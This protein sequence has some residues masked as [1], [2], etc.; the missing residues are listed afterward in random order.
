MKNFFFGK[1]FFSIVGIKSNE[2]LQQLKNNLSIDKEF[3]REK[4]RIALA[5]LTDKKIF[6]PEPK[7]N[8]Y[9]AV[10]V[11]FHQF[12]GQSPKY[13]IFGNSNLILRVFDAA[14]IDILLMKLDSFTLNEKLLLLQKFHS[15][16]VLKALM[17]N[18]IS[19]SNHFNCNS[20]QIGYGGRNVRFIFNDGKSLVQTNKMKQ[21]LTPDDI[22]LSK[23]ISNLL[24]QVDRDSYNLN[25]TISANELK[26]QIKKQINKIET[27]IAKEKESTVSNQMLVNGAVEIL[28]SGFA[29]TNRNSKDEED[30]EQEELPKPKK[31]KT[32]I[33]SKTLKTTK[34]TKPTN[35]PTKPPTNPTTNPPTNPTTNPTNPPNPPT[36]PTTNPTNP[37]RDKVTFFFILN[38]FI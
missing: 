30:D 8:P 6:D 15:T 34:P 12:L 4:F 38:F 24:Q 5:I 11:P 1:H 19:K 20:I 35:P 28:G 16:Y 18:H 3:Q 37:Q 25:I 17:S 27:E 13:S 33:A 32:T 21:K 14:S 29:S 9:P 26:S 31:Q 10:S 36:N 23:M 2:F 7:K 22:I